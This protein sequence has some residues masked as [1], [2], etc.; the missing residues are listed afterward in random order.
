[1]LAVF[2]FLPGRRW[3]VPGGCD[4]LPDFTLVYEKGAGTYFESKR[5]ENKRKIFPKNL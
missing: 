4:Y 5:P 1:M 2:F 3:N